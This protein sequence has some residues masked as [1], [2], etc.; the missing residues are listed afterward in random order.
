MTP[1]RC[2][3]CL[4][5]L[6]I[7]GLLLV[8]CQP[9]ATPPAAP[10]SAPATAAETT[11]ARI[12]REGIVRVGFANEKPF[13]YAQPDGLLGG[14][15]SDIARAVFARLGVDRMEG[16]LT[17]FG[18]LIPG[19][20]NER[21]DAIT[22]GMYIKPERCQQVLFADPEFKIGSG[23]LVT[24]GNPRNLHSYED[25]AAN[26]EVRVGTG[27]GYFEADYLAALGVQEGQIVLFADDA[28]GVAGVQAGQIDAYAAT[29][30]AVQ[31]LL[32]DAGDPGLEVA[33]PFRDP[34]IGG[35]P[36]TGYAGTA[37]RQEDAD[38]R[39]AFNVELA[40]LKASGELL[41]ILKAN[42]F[43]EANLPGEVTAEQACA[44]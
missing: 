8:A 41:K 7:A 1:Q 20:L 42:G 23:L 19:L 16:V 22:A 9:P 40:K 24:A 25:I 28:S 26:P 30:M 17:E 31:I 27:A 6:A 38:L 21:F 13:A 11:F 15:A 34:L 37:F 35:K 2:S 18:A 33:A 32:A 29:S 3:G 5:T 14:E 36:V 12:R 43:G 39:D 44:P 10:A 4:A